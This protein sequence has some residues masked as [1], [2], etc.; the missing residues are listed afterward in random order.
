L[1]LKYRP[2]EWMRACRQP[3]EFESEVCQM[4]ENIVGGFQ[5][6]NYATTRDPTTKYCMRLIE[7]FEALPVSLNEYRPTGGSHLILV[8]GR[9]ARAGLIRMMEAIDPTD[10]TYE[11]RVLDTE[12]AAWLTTQ[13]ITQEIGDVNHADVILVPGKTQ[14][15]VQDIARALGVQVL[16]GPECYSELPVF[17]EET[18]FED[19]VSDVPRPRLLVLGNQ[20]DSISEFITKTYQ[21]P[22]ITPDNLV[23]QAQQD[24][25]DIVAPVQTN[26][27][28]ELLRAR[29]IQ[30]DAKKG[31]VITGYPRTTR[32]VRW[33]RDIGARPDGIL[34]VGEADPELLDAYQDH[35]GRILIL[36]SDNVRDQ[37]ATALAHIETLMQQCVIPNSGAAPEKK[38]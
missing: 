6:T 2:E 12:I 26:V 5:R 4:R 3:I 15:D 35:P 33:L 38:D 31:Y 20:G 23:Q 7:L 21:V 14:G 18:G 11:I 27:M 8:T 9:L 32:D 29:L 25:L 28:A 1:G 30:P 17:F 36:P 19:Q 13:Q 34:F 10:F 24:G 16:R 22:L 37:Q